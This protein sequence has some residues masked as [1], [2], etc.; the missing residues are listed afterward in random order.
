MGSMLVVT[1]DEVRSATS[2]IKNSRKIGKSPPS[3]VT[4][5][6]AIVASVRVGVSLKSSAMERGVDLGD[7]LDRR[8]LFDTEK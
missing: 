8:E 6:A 4:P 1:T 5:P 2:K 7:H 3:V